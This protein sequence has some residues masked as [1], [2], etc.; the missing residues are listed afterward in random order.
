LIQSR[1]LESN[2]LDTRI[3]I[4]GAGISGLSAGFRLKEAGFDPVIFEKEPYTGGRMSSENVE[5][6]IIDKGAYT[7]PEFHKNLK[8]FVD[9]LGVG[10][11]LTQ[12]P[13]STSTF[14][15][16][17]H[18]LIKIGSPTDFLKQKLFSFKSKKDLIRLYL[19]AQSLGKA[20]NL[21]NPTQRTFQLEG[22]SAA[23][24]LMGKYDEEILEKVAYPIFSEIFL[25]APENNSKLAFLATLKNLTKFK[26][27]AFSKGMGS[28]ADRLAR[29]LDVRLDMPT[30]KITSMGKKGP[31]E[32]H[33]GGVHPASFVFD[34]IIFAIPST[35][36]PDIFDDFP[37]A[38]KEYVK[39]V[40]YA[41]SIVVALALD[42]RYPQASMINNLLRKDF[43]VLGNVIFD[44]HKSPDRVPEGKG[45]VT[46]ILSEKA[47]RALFEKSKESVIDEVFREMDS[48][49][50]H[51][52]DNLIFSKVYRWP[53][54]ALQ[55][56][57]GMLKKQFAVRKK[58]SESSGN[59]Y[60]AG[61]GL[62]RSSLE[63][64]FKTG[65]GAANQIIATAQ[66]CSN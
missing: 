55:M 52:T 60:L 3:A 30:I 49:L 58:L 10:E 53:H 9:T 5:G 22:E 34:A 28:L 50:P 24:F 1:G 41:P 56:G 51:L 33:V 14:S 38:L 31:Y 48:L 26:I 11:S 2:A 64:S 13:G 17:K 37:S 62:H 7:F 61:D 65:V 21:A 23:E 43:D 63:I 25:G 47:S 29:D 35:L 39:A 54:G 8:R 59:F 46:A 6:F 4:I 45:L 27:F 12:T 32:V 18:H 36:M 40:Q 20:L 57:T 44:H 16:G 42:R 66:S 15:S 19:Y